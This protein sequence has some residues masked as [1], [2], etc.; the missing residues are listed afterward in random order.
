MY[1]RDVARV[2]VGP[3]PREGA[4]SRDARGATL[5]GMIVMLRGANG[6]EVVSAVER[7]LAEIQPLLPRSVVIRPFYN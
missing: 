3:M 4:V 5:S 2:A 7:R 6:R 1:V